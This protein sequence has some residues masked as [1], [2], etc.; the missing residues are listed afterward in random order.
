[1]KKLLAGLGAKIRRQPRHRECGFMNCKA[2]YAL[3]AA[4]C[5]GLVHCTTAIPNP[6]NSVGNVPPVPSIAATSG[7]PQSHEVNGAFGTPLMA[8][9]TTNGSPTSGVAV[10]FTAPSTGASGAFSGTTSTT[11][12]TTD[13][14]GLATA[15]TFVA[16]GT[17]GSY[18][19]TA[20]ISG[21]LTPA[22]FNLTNTTGAPAAIIASGG[23][24]QHANVT[25]AFAQPLSVTVL[26]IGQNPVSG[27]VVV[28]MAP[29]T[30]ASGI[31]ADTQTNST[32]ATTNAAGVA[33][34]TIFTANSIAGA[35][36]VTAM[37]GGIST[38]ASFNL[39][40][41]AGAALSITA[42]G[43][44]PQSTAVSTAF[45]VPLTAT[46]VDQYS[47]P[48][49]G[50]VVTFA[51]PS[52]TGTASGT[53]ANGKTTETDATDATG[54]A[55]S[56]TFSANGVNGG[57][58][59]VTAKVSGVSLP[60]NFILTNTVTSTTYVFYLRGQEA[61]YGPNFYALAGAVKIDA[62]GN[63]LSGEQDYNDGF[64]VA[65][66]QPLGD[67]ING[68]TL[69]VDSTGQGTLTLNTSN[70]AVGVSGVETLGVQFANANHAQVIQ[71]DGTATSNGSLDLQTLPTSLDGSYAFTLTGVDPAY[72]PVGFGGVFTIS[73]G[74][75][76]QSGLIDTNDAGTSTVLLGTAL[77]GTISPPDSLGRGFI[78][79]FTDPAFASTISINYYAVGPEVIR[80]IDVDNQATSGV[81][82]TDSA[83]GSAFGQG[84]NAS[85]ATNA[86]LGGSVFGI[87]G[88][89][90]SFNYDVVGLF[91]TN[92]SAGTFSGVADDNEM[93]SFLLFTDT[94]IS[95]NYSIASNG[96]GNLTIAAGVL[97]DISALGVYL[98]DPQLNLDDPNNTATGLGGALIADMDPV[99]GTTGAVPAGGTGILI[100]TDT[101][102]SFTGTYAFGA[103]GNNFGAEF[104]FVGVGPVTSGTLNGTGILSDPFISFGFSSTNTGATFSA[105]PQ[106]DPNAAGRYTMLSTNTVPN[107][108]TVAIAGTMLP[109]PFDVVIYQGSGGQLF[110]L[111][112]DFGFGFFGILEPQGS[113][114]G[115]PAAR[116]GARKESSAFR[117]SPRHRIGQF[118]SPRRY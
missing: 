94:P 23:N 15:A 61:L 115:L 93:S 24:A 43:G 22:T 55:T 68:G 53:F 11:T 86:S 76:L 58:Y 29:A 60:A 63:V 102:A 66:P 95:G 106:A 32:T 107:P 111:D 117:K 99:S 48:V 6:N 92:S 35:D 87:E 85:G 88:S 37:V 42:T 25:S 96:Y 90:F 20:S 19:V 16:N 54:V 69:S 3:L 47:N 44:T 83:V 38:P 84:A 21:S 5:L 41:G 7:T 100:P 71:F 39:I 18:A 114:T 31:F 62:Q 36:T 97:G 67:L 98:T 40:N 116:V 104:D 17:A 8:T 64:V 109:G 27:A 118:F 89:T 2:G 57:P 81:F 50:A 112:E 75:T 10:T 105:T 91:S 72:S 49:S 51:A 1:M 65:S 13:S 12:V 33:T 110:W 74:T 78:S 9:V 46:V 45:S 70:P 28:F 103:R 30:G 108:L 52:A 80:L 34:S 56:T 79:G 59:T 77:S 4:V 101:S 82:T 14:N 73:G 113:L 26:D